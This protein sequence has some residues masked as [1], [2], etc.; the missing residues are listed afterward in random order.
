[1]IEQECFDCKEVRTLDYFGSHAKTGHK[2]ICLSCDSCSCVNPQ[3]CRFDEWTEVKLEFLE[4]KY[5]PPPPLIDRNDPT[6][7]FAYLED[8][9]FEDWEVPTKLRDIMKLGDAWAGPLLAA[10]SHDKVDPEIIKILRNYPR[11]LPLPPIFIFTL[12][13]ECFRI[14]MEECGIGIDYVYALGWYVHYMEAF[15]I[16]GTMKELARSR[17]NAEDK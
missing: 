15:L 13:V 10:P 12:A 9:F 14:G 6:D 11:T 5:N 7:F 4:L 1:M 2:N 3:N 17:I 8:G 16:K